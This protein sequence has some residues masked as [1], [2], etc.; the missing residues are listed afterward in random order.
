MFFKRSYFVDTC[1]AAC[2][3]KV[4]CY[5]GFALKHILEKKRSTKRKQIQQKFD[6]C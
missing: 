4:T 1:I 3:Y 6:N 5:L 2:R